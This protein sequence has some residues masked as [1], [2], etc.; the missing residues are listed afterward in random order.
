MNSPSESRGRFH[1]ELYSSFDSFE[2]QYAWPVRLRQA[3]FGLPRFHLE[4][5]S[6]YDAVHEEPDYAKFRWNTQCGPGCL[7][8]Y[9]FW[10]KTL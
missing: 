4:F 1:S 2:R 9:L 8:L 10:F 5:K 3:N 6:A 7:R